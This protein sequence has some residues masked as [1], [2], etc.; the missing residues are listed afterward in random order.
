MASLQEI[1]DS[2]ADA[3]SKAAAGIVQVNG[4]RGGPASGIVWANG[5]V[6]TSSHV[7][8]SD[9]DI[10]VSDGENEKPATV[11]GRDPGTDI[12]VL[13]VEG[14]K[15]TQAERGGEAR[16]GEI[17]LA[18]GRPGELQVSL[19]VVAST[20]GRQRG[21]RGRGLSG[22]LVTDAQLFE[23]FS[24]G[25]LVDASGRVLGVN[26]WYY[27]RG[28]T[29]ALP[30]AAADRVAQSLLTHGKVP[31]PYLGIGTQP[32]YLDE[33]QRAAAGQDSGLMVVSVEAGS[34]AATAGVLQGDVLVALGGAATARMRDL[35]A[36]LTQVDVGSSQ[37]LKV[38]RAG[39]IKELSATIGERAE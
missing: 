20:A 2:L 18:V 30:A 28:T 38:V 7:L 17:V 34:P 26:S 37:T 22:L 8:D 10:T 15:A 16:P 32:V 31:Q 6:L 19:G 5:V 4:R 27:G 24:G 1:S 9:E 21:W 29:R 36:A 39:E 23:G 33:A 3:A 14:L 11:A 35:Y 12:A 13:K 25:A